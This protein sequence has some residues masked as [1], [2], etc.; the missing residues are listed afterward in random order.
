MLQPK[1]QHLLLL[2]VAVVVI[3]NAV[4]LVTTPPEPVAPMDGTQP[5]PSHATT[6]D[7]EL[8]HPAGTA[9]MLPAAPVRLQIPSIGVDSELM[10]LGLQADG[11][12]EV[13]SRG[14]PAGWYTGSPTPGERGPAIIAGHVDWAGQPGVFFDL[15]GLSPGA[16][17][18]ITRQDASTARFRVTRVER[19][20]KDKFPTQA[21]YGD[22]DHAGLRLITCGGQFDRQLRSYSDNIVVFAELVASHPPAAVLSTG[23]VSSP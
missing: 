1:L 9:T 13:P 7:A 17:I 10:D 16:E 22:L 19:F 3:S 21:V 4:P 2:L 23:P 15:R 18:S 6:S 12:L 20:A 14:F 5:Q 8:T 11:T